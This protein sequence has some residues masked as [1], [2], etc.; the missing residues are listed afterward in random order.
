[1]AK[2]PRKTRVDFHGCAQMCV[3]GR[4]RKRSHP[5]C[6]LILAASVKRPS[7]NDRVAL[8]IWRHR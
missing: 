1:M 5:S 8:N 6:W 7:S 2:H 4:C 3:A